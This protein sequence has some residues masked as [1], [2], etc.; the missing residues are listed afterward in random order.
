MSNFYDGLMDN[1]NKLVGDLRP[2]DE[3]KEV[4]KR[5]LTKKEFKYFKLLIDGCSKEDMLKELNCDDERFEEISKQTILKINQE[6]L[7]HELTHK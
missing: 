2:E 5:R 4:L 3:L 7:K 6:K 1:I